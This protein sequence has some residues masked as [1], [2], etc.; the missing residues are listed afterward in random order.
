MDDD[1]KKLQT[2]MINKKKDSN[3]ISSGLKRIFRKTSP[4]MESPTE[5][6]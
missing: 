5:I 2:R 6:K 3:L 4:Y 1:R